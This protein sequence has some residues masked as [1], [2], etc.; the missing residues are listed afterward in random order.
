LIDCRF[1]VA[2]NLAGMGNV[3][4]LALPLALPLR[5]CLRRHM[6]LGLLSKLCVVGDFNDIRIE[7]IVLDLLS[8]TT[9]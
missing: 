1:R 3:V 8:T 7:M 9:Q 5:S 4:V 6:Y 2:E